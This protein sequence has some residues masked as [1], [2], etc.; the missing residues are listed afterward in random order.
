MRFDDKFVVE[1]GW[2]QD[3]EQPIKT[4][5]ADVTIDFSQ[6]PFKVVFFSDNTGILTTT[7]NHQVMK[8][9]EVPS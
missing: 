5:C 2:H 1:H 4:Q 6:D 9:V 8:Q 3:R 7:R